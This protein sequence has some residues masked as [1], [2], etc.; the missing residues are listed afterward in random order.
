[1]SESKADALARKTETP[2]EALI[3][4]GATVQQIR[5]RTVTAMRCQVE[6]SL[7]TVAKRVVDECQF[8]PEGLTYSW[9]AGGKTIEGPSI[10]MA[11][12]LARNWSNAETD[13]ELVSETETHWIFRG[14]FYDFELGSTTSRLYRQRKPTKGKGKMD[15]D[16]Q[17]DLDFQI[18]QSKAIRNSVLNAMP[19][20][21]VKRATDAAKGHLRKEVEQDI[22]GGRKTKA[23]GKV[24]NAFKKY[25]ISMDMLEAKI[26][27]KTNDWTPDDIQTLYSLYQAL[28]DGQTSKD[29]EF[30]GEDA[31]KDRT[32]FGNAF[33]GGDSEPE[34]AE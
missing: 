31:K 26:D 17:E 9:S 1:M 27:K 34:A 7:E 16:R 21:L 12:I 20:G 28:E 10:K 6:R 11:M 2:G 18:G 32:E 13:A 14:L 22:K 24:E 33:G 23:L 4:G 15:K 3:A 19:A 29:N 25:D 8:D 30:G 5:T